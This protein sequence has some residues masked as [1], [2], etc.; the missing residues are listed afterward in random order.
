MTKLIDLEVELLDYTNENGVGRGILK[1]LCPVCIN[2]PILGM[3]HSIRTPITSLPAHEVPYDP[4]WFYKN[5]TEAK[6][7]VWQAKGEFPNLTLTP[8]INIVEKDENGNTIRTLCWHGFI[9][10]GET[11]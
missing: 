9:V 2:N 10:N 3:R 7:Y 1:Y 4:P 8:S 11:S 5:G 6:K